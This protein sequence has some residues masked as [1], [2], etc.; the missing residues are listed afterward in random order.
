MVRK[1]R[2]G[3]GIIPHFF[4]DCVSNFEEG[5]LFSIPPPPISLWKSKYPS[6]LFYNRKKGFLTD[7]F[8]LFIATKENFILS[9]SILKISEIIILDQLVLW[10]RFFWS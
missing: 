10:L 4:S 1:K 3:T 6:K 5:Q 9:D 8:F 2:I 7:Y